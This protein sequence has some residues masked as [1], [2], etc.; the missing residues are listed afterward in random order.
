MG[1][2]PESLCVGRVYS[3]D[4]FVFYRISFYIIL[5]YD[6]IKYTVLMCI[7]CFVT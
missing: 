5:I 2:G 3:A 7:C 4:N 6:K 1:G